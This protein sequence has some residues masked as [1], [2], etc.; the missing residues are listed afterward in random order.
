MVG[1]QEAWLGVEQ[2]V[3]ME[4]DKE[5][6]TSKKGGSGMKRAKKG[7]PVSD[8]GC[9]V[10]KRAREEDEEDDDDDDKQL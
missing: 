9:E 3:E 6:R 8:E 4:E 2:D 5:L 1:L 7:N 10:L